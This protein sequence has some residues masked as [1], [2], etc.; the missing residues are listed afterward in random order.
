MVEESC[1]LGRGLVRHSLEA[2]LLLRHCVPRHSRPMKAQTQAVL[3][4]GCQFVTS[5]WANQV[6]LQPVLTTSVHAPNR[7]ERAC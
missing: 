7:C 4:N 2:V 1:S 3:S 5:V 6:T